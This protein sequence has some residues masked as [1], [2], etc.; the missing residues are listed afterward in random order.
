MAEALA[1]SEPA[2]LR[3]VQRLK[4]DGWGVIRHDR[5]A[6]DDGRG[7]RMGELVLLDLEANKHQCTVDID[8]KRKRACEWGKLAHDWEHGIN[9]SAYD[10]YRKYEH[11]RGHAAYVLIV[12]SG[13]PDLQ[14]ARSRGWPGLP[15]P[16]APAALIARVTYLRVHYN[17][18][19]GIPLVY[20]PRSQ[21]RSDWLA[22]LNR[23]VLQSDW[24]PARRRQREER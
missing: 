1:Y 7:P 16:P 14:R 19:N 9:A 15:L 20:W 3:A 21:M 8:V 10:H 2:V 24:A 11:L 4:E 12:E 6:T 5:I 13:L 23:H 22:V 17:E 18:D